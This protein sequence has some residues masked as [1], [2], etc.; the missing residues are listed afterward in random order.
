LYQ[1]NKL[2]LN[3]SSAFLDDSLA[4]VINSV[5]LKSAKKLATFSTNAG[6]FH[7]PLKGTGAKKGESVSIKYLSLG[8]IL[9]HSCISYAFGKVTIPLKLI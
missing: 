8:T 9:A 3:K 2:N 6:S 1:L 4:I 5:D 7:L